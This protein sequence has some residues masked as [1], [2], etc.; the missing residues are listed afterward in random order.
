MVLGQ[1][2]ATAAAQAIDA[3]VAVQDLEY[4]D[5]RNRLKADGQVLRSIGK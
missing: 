2:A 3:K 1:S 5:L 4:A